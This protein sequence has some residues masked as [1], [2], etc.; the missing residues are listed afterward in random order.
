M[1]YYEFFNPEEGDKKFLRNTDAYIP[2]YTSVPAPQS[3]VRILQKC[4]LEVGL[5]LMDVLSRYL[6]GKSEEDHQK[7]QLRYPLFDCM[8]ITLP[9]CRPGGSKC[10]LIGVTSVSVVV[11]KYNRLNIRILCFLE[12]IPYSEQETLVLKSWN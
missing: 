11:M 1:E 2:N 9:F 8:S 12:S 7:L 5:S 4:F 10:R 3:S 6:P